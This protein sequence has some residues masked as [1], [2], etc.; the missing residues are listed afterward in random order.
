MAPNYYCYWGKAG[1]A[2]EP[3]PEYHLLAYHCLDVA[4]VGKIL[5][6]QRPG[7][8]KQ[9]AD[10]TGLPDSV[11]TSWMLFFLALHDLGKWSGTFQRQR[12]DIATQ[13]GQNI[14]LKPSSMRHD[15]LGYVLWKNHLAKKLAGSPHFSGREWLKNDDW[16]NY[17]L[18][19]CM[20]AVTGHHGKPP[21]VFE[22]GIREI[23]IRNHY[24]EQDQQAAEMFTLEISRLLLT[25]NVFE[26]HS[27]E[28]FSG[29][30]RQ[31]SWNLAGFAILCDWL[32]SNAEYFNYCTEIQPLDEYW[33]M[34]LN[35]AARIVHNT[36]F[37][38]PRLKSNVT[39]KNI[40]PGLL[41]A[42]P[43]QNLAETQTLS[44]QPQLF[45]IEDVTGSGKTEAAL[46]LAQRLMHA[47]VARGLYY[48]LPTMAT[49]NA[50]FSRVQNTLPRMFDMQ[51]AP[52]LILAHSS[53]RLVE[54]FSQTV[55]PEDHR[56]EAELND[57]EVPA[58]TRCSAW[59][60]DNNKK[61]LLADVGVGTLDQALLGILPS[62]HQSLRLFGLNGKLLIVDEVHAC[63]A[64]VHML[65]QVLLRHHAASGGSVILLSATLPLKMRRELI[66]AYAE[67]RGQ[68]LAAPSR[69]DSSFPL[70]T[71][72]QDGQL[73]SYPIDTFPAMRRPIKLAYTS[74]LE[75]VFTEIF[76]TV[77]LGG[78]ACWLRN[79]VGDARQGFVELKRRRPEAN[80]FL[81]HA[82]YA[83]GDRLEIEKLVLKLFGKQSTPD[84]RKGCILV[85]T[86]VVEQ[87]L[88]L[89]FDFMVSDLA[90]IDRL[91]Q[92]AGR[93]HRHTRKER[94][95]EAQ[96]LVHGPELV[97]TPSQ[98]WYS[99]T[100][101][102]A[103]YVY[104][105]PGRLYLTA[106]LVVEKKILKLPDDVRFFV[107]T[108]Y[109][110]NAEIP[111]SLLEKHDRH[112]G[113]ELAQG[114]TAFINALKMNDGYSSEQTANWQDEARA[115]TRLGEPTLEIYLAKLDHGVI[116]PWFSRTDHYW[117]LS[118]L[119]LRAVQVSGD[120]EPV[121]PELKKSYASA[122]KTLPDQGR[123]CKILLLCECDAGLFKC[124]GK[125]PDGNDTA[126]YYSLECGLMT[127]REYLGH[128][129]EPD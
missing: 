61:S 92:R 21:Q 122:M 63:D 20:Q 59:L 72:W 11:F 33:N 85:A 55:M 24:S 106:K 67:G 25:D 120:F 64:Y 107:E 13:L 129:F 40:F 87:S 39:F 117:A 56:D 97:E 8:L 10:Q 22:F 93:L 2:S 105:D 104:E 79:T 37:G 124:S 71:H 94:S 73:Q 110:V 38:S 80:V 100:F 91:I 84:I 125:K 76:K 89:D 103:A 27:I 7:L 36:G 6:E 118:L 9:L 1:V 60:A 114:G 99:S 31:A 74:S 119:R 18:S 19:Y 62:R 75:N 45:V 95:G 3:L 51:S 70:L 127:A 30:M 35:K 4:A 53:R 88:D 102:S 128:S 44:T 47:G 101:P 41:Q 12:G 43:L 42:S 17:V 98:T 50:M 14:S 15:S 123:W 121:Q 126:L 29:N 23:R 57:D 78:C 48:A 115:P 81:F 5:L 46:L 82:R 90:P 111:D 77:D 54:D 86:Q 52:S 109:G 66:T 65:L 49:A 83:M 112:H 28:V 96:L 69:Q 116:K 113:K 68:T 108:V 26:P 34:A 16:R 32:G 58:T